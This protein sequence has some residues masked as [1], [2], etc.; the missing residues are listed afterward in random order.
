VVRV[1]VFMRPKTDD[2]ETSPSHTTTYGALTTPEGKFSIMGVD[3]GSYIIILRKVGFISKEDQDGEVLTLSPGEKKEDLNL[4]LVPYGAI[5][6]RVL[7]S[8]ALPMGVEVDLEGEG[9]DVGARAG[10]D[11]KGQ[12]RMEG[13]RPGRYRVRA[14]PTPIHN[15]PEIR[16]DGTKQAHYAATYYPGALA[17]SEAAQVE[18]KAG[19]E[20]PGL[21][22][23]LAARPG[24]RVSGTVSGLPQ[25]VKDPFL[26]AREQMVKAQAVGGLK[27]DGTFEIWMV[28]PGTYT[29]TASY[30]LGGADVESS[31]AEIHVAD[32]DIDNVALHFFPP[33]DL[34]GRLEFDQD[35]ARPQAQ[36]EEEDGEGNRRRLQ[37]P[38]YG[39]IDLVALDALFGGGSASLDARGSLKFTGLSPNHYDVRLS[40]VSEPKYVKSIRVGSRLTEGPILDLTNGG[41][42]LTIVVSTAMGAISGRVTD[43]IGPAGGGLV[44]LLPVAPFHAQLANQ[45]AARIQ[46]D[47]SYQFDKVAPGEYR[48]VAIRESS[49]SFAVYHTEEYKPELERITIHP[50]DRLTKDLR[51]REPQ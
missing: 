32:T 26:M 35:G 23:R 48:I 27:P 11:E 28:D 9:G 44:M 45:A 51:I 38:W 18:V 37:Q 21:D 20:T 7:A 46:P 5:S 2:S 16:N 39:R 10:V 22:I 1:D 43:G 40:W 19:V 41:G 50:R 17:A 12:Y 47:G 4:K 34:I 49:Y 25:G 3:P 36:Y 29:L 42:P 31:S 33:I 8:D 13:L 24:V 6:G 15:R 30:R 14:V